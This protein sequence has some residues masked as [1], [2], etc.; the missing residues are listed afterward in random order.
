MDKKNILSWVIVLGLIVGGVY[1]YKKGN[2]E[3]VVENT[4]SGSTFSG[5][6]EEVNTGCFADG[7]C[8]V[9]IDKKHVTV[10]MGWTQATVGSIIGV[11][12]F[13]DL[14]THKGDIFEVYAEKKA[15]G[16]YTLYGS[17]KYYVK[18]R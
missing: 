13:G 17:E 18:L 2:K 6:L 15:D 5:K 16:T 7:E 10:I 9:V 14:E 8:Y 1:L 11:G 12:S 3:N 4:N